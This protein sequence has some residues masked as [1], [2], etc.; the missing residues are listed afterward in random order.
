MTL[1]NSWI[2]YK[3]IYNPSKRHRMFIQRVSEELMGA[4]HTK[5]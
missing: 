5:G 3:H 1:T 4:L 2:I